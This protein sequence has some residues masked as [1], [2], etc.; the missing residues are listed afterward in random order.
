M[1]QTN[2]YKLKTKTVA[3]SQHQDHTGPYFLEIA[4]ICRVLCPCVLMHSLDL[5]LFVFLS[6]L[7][8][9]II[10][11]SSKLKV[12]FIKANFTAKVISFFRENIRMCSTDTEMVS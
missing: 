1:S 8:S 5:V 9:Q 6:F 11:P 2:K 7:Y 10:A 3:Y 12:L 4:A